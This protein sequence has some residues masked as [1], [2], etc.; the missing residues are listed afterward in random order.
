MSKNEILAALPRLSRAERRQ[1]VKRVFDLEEDRQVLE[2]CDRR[3]DGNFLML[4]K[5]EAENAKASAG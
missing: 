3:A 2:D 1:I 4:D 5:M